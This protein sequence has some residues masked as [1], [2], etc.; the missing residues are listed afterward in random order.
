VE[1]L[2][3]LSISVS[4]LVLGTGL[5]LIL[6]PVADPVGLPCRSRDWSTRWWP[7]PSSCAD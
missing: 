4:P 3:A 2:T 1:T 5:F 6:F 7:C